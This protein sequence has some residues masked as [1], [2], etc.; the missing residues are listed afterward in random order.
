MR[1]IRCLLVVV[2]ACRVTTALAQQD[3]FTGVEIKA[4]K[5]A[6]G[7]YMLE[8]RGGNLAVSI[9]EDGVL[10]VDD[11][12]APLASKIEAAI[13]KL[14]GGKPKFILNTHWHGDHTGGNEHFGK[15]GTIIAHENVRARLSTKQELFGKSYG[16]LEK[17]GIPVITFGEGLNVHFNGE[18]IRAWHLPG[19]HTDGDCVVLFPKANVIHMGDLMFMGMLP[20]VDLDHGGGVQGMIDNVEKVLSRIDQMPPDSRSRLKII[21]GHGPLST[22]S[23]L[24][25]YHRMLKETTEHVRNGMA[26]GKSLKELKAAGIPEEWKPWGSGIVKPD[27]WVET[28]FKSYGGKSGS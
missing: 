14:G 17:E 12:Y 20:F 8:G 18:D 16:P 15:G 24:R 28:I 26:A 19:G 1:R 21:P 22:E 9:G 10:M 2:L 13:E 23:D 25:T 11:Q 7:L 5:V 3:D 6:D 4:T 27:W